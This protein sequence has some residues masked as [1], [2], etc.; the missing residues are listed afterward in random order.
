M[1]SA[2]TASVPRRS[3]RLPA[4]L[5]PGFPAGSLDGAAGTVPAEGAERSE[6]PTPPAAQLLGK[7]RPLRRVRVQG[8]RAWYCHPGLSPAK[9]REEGVWGKAQGS[10]L[11]L[12]KA[13]RGGWGWLAKLLCCLCLGVLPGGMAVS[14]LSQPGQRSQAQR[15]WEALWASTLT[16][17]GAWV[18]VVGARGE[19]G[20]SGEGAPVG[21]Q[22]VVTCYD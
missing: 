14:S 6:S 20:R 11:L 21:P 7:L 15:P 18:C 3:A 17:E 13:G 5:H 9:G 19:A 4:R 22:A 2:R 12:Q 10:L 16:Q 1:T 8:A